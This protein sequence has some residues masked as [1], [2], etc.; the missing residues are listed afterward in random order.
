MIVIAEFIRI[1]KYVFK[2]VT[3]YNRLFVWAII[4]ISVDGFPL[5][6]LNT[7]NRPLSIVFL[8]SFWVITKIQKI[9]FSK[10]EIQVFYSYLFLLIF[11]IIQSGFVLHS[12]R[13]VLKFGI[14]G[15]FSFITI[16]CCFIFFSSIIRK[17]SFEVLMKV[18]KI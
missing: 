9:Q 6:P 3:G 15:L 4:W 5:I 2:T 8:L 7:N 13:P 18:I 16:S 12:F 1:Y 11:S 10:F 17:G 14:T